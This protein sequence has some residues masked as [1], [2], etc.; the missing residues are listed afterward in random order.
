MLEYMDDLMTRQ[1]LMRVMECTN[2]IDWLIELEFY[3]VIFN[4]SLGGIKSIYIGQLFNFR[5]LSFN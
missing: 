1:K 3:W 5:I 4:E 2:S